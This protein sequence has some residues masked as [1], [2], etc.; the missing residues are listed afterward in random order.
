[1]NAA[2]TH[3]VAAVETLQHAA[4]W[5]AWK[6]NERESD[7]LKLDAPETLD[8]VV[9]QAMSGISLQPGDTLAIQCSHAGRGK[10]TLWLLQVKRSTKVYDYRPSANGGRPV[11]VG[12]LYPELVAQTEL[13][14]PFAPVP[15][16]DAFRD[17]PVGRDAQL[18]EVRP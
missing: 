9:A 7:A 6:L 12:R 10:N 8:E 15:R 16:F 14:A 2:V 11:R 13:A 1:M 4:A 5:S 18:V 17:C 3:F